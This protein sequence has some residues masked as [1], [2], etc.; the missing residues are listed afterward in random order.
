MNITFETRTGTYTWD[1]GTEVAFEEWQTFKGFEPNEPRVPKTIVLR[2]VYGL[3]IPKLP[4]YSINN[5]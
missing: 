4:L 2:F 1:D 3:K 5:I